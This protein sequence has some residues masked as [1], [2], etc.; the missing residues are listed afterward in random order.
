MRILW[1]LTLMLAGA[2][3]PSAARTWHVEKDGS[4][5]FTV[6]QAA[7]D[8][9]APGDTISIGP[10]RYTEKAPLTAL[11]WTE[12]VNVAVRT[13]SL[14]LIGAGRDLTIIGPEHREYSPPA[15]PKGIAAIYLKELAVRG[16]SIENVYDGVFRYGGALTF[17]ECEV[18]NCDAG[19]TALTDGGMLIE[20]CRFLAN[21]GYG[22]ITFGPAR[23][24]LVHNC[25]FADTEAGVSFNNGTLNALVEKCEFRGGLVGASIQVNSSGQVSNCRFTEVGNF[26]IDVAIASYG[27][28][29][30]N[31]IV[32]GGN[33][34][35]V[36]SGCYVT[37]SGNL[38][39]CGRFSTLRIAHSTVDLHGNHILNTGAS[40]VWLEA[41]LSDPVVQLDLTGNYWGTA[42]S[43]TIAGW[44]HDGNDDPSIHAFVQ[45]EPFSAV[46][47]PT[48]KKS[49]GGVKGL[50]R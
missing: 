25:Y 41:Y 22:V 49:L 2:A 32:N 37:G 11:G 20:A 28:L 16:L 14:T 45:Y 39:G 44:I 21:D 33:S 31:T 38:F 48:E 26:G 18:R 42:D 40:S 24:I 43:T 10:G 30:G 6:I 29:T 15:M 7:V 5:D 46:P 36:D 47:L 1:A 34:L 35:G 8:A 13:D 19:I 23:D 50:Y 12:Y 27:V 17:L 3:V 9:A 4:G